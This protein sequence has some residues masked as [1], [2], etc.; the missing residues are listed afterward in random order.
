MVATAM[1]TIRVFVMFSHYKESKATKP[2]QS[3][4]NN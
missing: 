4:I 2:D 3:T 1:I